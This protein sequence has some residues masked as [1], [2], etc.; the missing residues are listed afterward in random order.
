MSS[1]VWVVYQKPHFGIPGIAYLIAGYI[2]DVF[3]YGRFAIHAKD[4]LRAPEYGMP[5]L[6]ADSLLSAAPAGKKRVSLVL[7]PFAFNRDYPPV[8]FDH[9]LRAEFG[10]TCSRKLS[11]DHSSWDSIQ[12]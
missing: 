2:E 9:F 5:V 8:T 4:L 1:I 7:C 3:D 6:N 12:I 11:A 10:I